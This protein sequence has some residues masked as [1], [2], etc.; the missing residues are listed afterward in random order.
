MNADSE[1]SETF[2]EERKKVHRL[3]KVKYFEESFL[4]VHQI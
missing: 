4:R 1:R 3:L 2:E